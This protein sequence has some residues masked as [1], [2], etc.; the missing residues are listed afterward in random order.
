VGF[1]G[2]SYSGLSVNSPMQTESGSID[3]TFRSFHG[4]WQFGV[5]GTLNL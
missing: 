2:G 1:F 4:W 3:S 5:K